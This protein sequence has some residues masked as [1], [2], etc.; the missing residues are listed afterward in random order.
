LITISTRASLKKYHTYNLV[1]GMGERGDEW[2]FE[3][4]GTEREKMHV[5]RELQDLRERLAQVEKWQA[6]REEIEKELAKVWVEGGDDLDPPPY[7]ETAET[8][9]S[10]EEVEQSE[11]VSRL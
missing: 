4:I 3:R 5:E 6:R 7:V 8:E 9:T 1:L 10:G 11:P 2:E